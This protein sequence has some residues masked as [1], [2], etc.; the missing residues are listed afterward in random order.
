MRLSEQIMVFHNS[1][2]ALDFLQNT[3][4]QPLFILC[5]I[6][7]PKLNGFQLRTELLKLDSAIK[8]TPFLFL[9]TSQSERDMSQ[10]G[11]LKVQG[12]YTK[13]TTIDGVKETFEKIL[14]LLRHLS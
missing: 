5:D 1:M 13:S 11:E 8:E 3:I 6:N 14:I 4:L 2:D 10:A 7:M 12:Y 9:S